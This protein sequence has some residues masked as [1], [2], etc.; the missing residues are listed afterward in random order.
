MASAAVM[1]KGGR[2]RRRRGSYDEHASSLYP[3]FP[4]L[5]ISSFSP[6][7]GNT[8]AEIEQ[9]KKYVGHSAGYKKRREGKEKPLEALGL[10]LGGGMDG[11]LREEKLT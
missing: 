7:P 5:S 6:S 3:L 10:F 4:L 9:L 1:K 2:R 11:W 8:A